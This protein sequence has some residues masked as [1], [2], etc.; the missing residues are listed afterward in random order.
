MHIC[1]VNP[2]SPFLIND[3]GAP[4]L[5]ILH[6]AA[7][8]DAAGMA[9]SLWDMTGDKKISKALGGRSED[10][11]GMIKQRLQWLIEALEDQDNPIDLFA[12]TAASAQ[13][14]AAKQLMLM[15]HHNWPKIPIAIGGPHVSAL[16]QMALGD[17]FDLVVVGE[18]DIDFPDFL[19]NYGVDGL[20]QRPFILTCK[21]EPT[22]LN[23]LHFPLRELVNL[24]SYCANLPVGEGLATTIHMSRGCPY[25]CAYC[26]RTLGSL[27]R[28]LRVRSIGNIWSELTHI[29]DTY[30]I[31]R[32]VATDDIWG[33]KKDWV[34]EF[35][36]WMEGSHFRFRVNCRAN[37][38]HRELLPA[39]RRA[40]ITVISFGFESGSERVLAAISKNSVEANADAIKACHD[41]GIFVKAYLI[42]GFPEDDEASAEATKK[43]IETSKPDSAQIAYL[44]PLP[45]TPIYEKAIAG[46]WKP[47]YSSLYHNGVNHRGGMSR[48]PWHTDET[49]EIYE[50]LVE[51]T[52]QHYQKKQSS[53]DCPNNLGD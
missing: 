1:F 52:E 9:V 6:L 30:G 26:V 5:G 7:E 44:V 29:R 32:F 37:T 46:G 13:Y 2:P 22:D 17:G 3:R 35:C 31:H 16:P 11:R 4:P 40:G 20:R 27:A 42:F 49:A 28:R 45:G 41:A 25:A 34:Q 19:I 38:L 43:F 24:D 33:V 36:D 14:D 23:A 8:C 18:A 10:K 21:R 12:I 51:W 50:D 53:L 15:I 39:M 47:N 48:L